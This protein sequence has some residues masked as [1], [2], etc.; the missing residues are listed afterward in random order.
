MENDYLL[1][2]NVFTVVFCL[3]NI[4]CYSVINVSEYN[5]DMS[6]YRIHEVSAA[7]E[8]ISYSFLF[9]CPYAF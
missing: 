8:N 3:R 4:V 2:T 9:Y 7:Q 5:P 6:G 1:M